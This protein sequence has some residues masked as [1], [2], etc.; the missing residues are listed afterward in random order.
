MKHGA[1]KMICICLFLFSFFTFPS[2]SEA[3]GNEI[4]SKKVNQ[5]VIRG[6]EILYD[7]D[8]DQAEK[9]FYKVIAENPKDPI[10]YF[11]LAMVSWSQLASGFWSSE[12]VKEYGNRIDKAISVARQKIEEGSPDS[13]TF[14]YL[15]GALGFKGRFQLMERKWFSSFL[16]AL[17]AI[18]ALKTCREMDPENRDVLFGLGIFDYYT[19][20]LSGVLKFLTY[21]LLHQGDKEEGLRKLHLAAD[22]AVYSSIEAKSLLMHIYLFMEEE[23]EK[24]L[25]MVKEL[26][27]RFKNNSRNKYLEGATYIFLEREPEYR[28]I[29]D[30]FYQRARNEASITDASLWRKRALYLEASYHLFFGQSNTA[31]FKLESILSQAEPDNDPFMIGWP[32]LKMGMSWDMEDKREQAVSYYKKVM[33]MENGAGAQFLA[34]KYLQNPAKKKDPFLCY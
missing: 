20:R 10:G 3:L 32:L 31:R 4:K 25:P 18:E 11:Y 29:V 23:R 5:D 24:A 15:G 16:L 9:L 19:A 14:F 26:V 21:F 12:V 34:E 6:I 30:I 1:T 17:E 22:E 33:S 28:A 13:F 27:G 2:L 8:F 7:W